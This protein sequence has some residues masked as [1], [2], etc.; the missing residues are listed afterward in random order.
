MEFFLSIAIEERALGDFLE[1][2]NVNNPV[3]M[4]TL[5]AETAFCGAACPSWIAKYLLPLCRTAVYVLATQRCMLG[6][7]ARALTSLRVK[8]TSMRRVN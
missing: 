6:K 5:T 4:G 2:Q 7:S 3:I 1:T 8:E